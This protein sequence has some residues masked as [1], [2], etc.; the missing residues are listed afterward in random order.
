MFMESDLRMF[1]N[2]D[3]DGDFK[4]LKNAPTNFLNSIKITTKI[5]LLTASSEI[6]LLGE[7]EEYLTLK[8]CE[9]KF[10]TGL[11]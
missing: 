10:F 2:A 11:K 8:P 6:A 3:E 5:V 7:H 1:L 9:V 4:Q